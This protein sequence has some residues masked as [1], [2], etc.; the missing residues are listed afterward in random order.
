MANSLIAT[1]VGLDFDDAL[2]VSSTAMLMLSIFQLF[3][4]L[5]HYYLFEDFQGDL[6]FRLYSAPCSKV[7]FILSM[8]VAVWMY[9]FF[10]GLFF[11]ITSTL[12]FGV[13]WGNMF[14]VLLVLFMLSVLAQIISVLIFF[15]SPRRSVAEAL[16]QCFAWSAVILSGGLVNLGTNPIMVFFQMYGTPVSVAGRAMGAAAFSDVPNLGAPSLYITILAAYIGVFTVITVIAGM[17]CKKE[18]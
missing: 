3:S 18:I 15:I 6:R 7:K 17:L 16:M 11:I 9:S 1:T 10:I 5:Q 13:E 8:G 2:V 14:V 4:P 12:L